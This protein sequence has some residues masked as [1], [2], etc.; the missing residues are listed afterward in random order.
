MDEEGGVT[1]MILRLPLQ[2]QQKRQCG[3]GGKETPRSMGQNRE[4]RRP[5]KHSQLVFNKG[6][7]AVQGR[8]DRQP[9][10]NWW[11]SNRTFIDKMMNLDL[12]LTTYKKLIPMITDLNIKCKRNTFKKI[13]NL[14]DLVLGKEYL[15]LTTKKTHESYI[16]ILDP[17]RLKYFALCKSQLRE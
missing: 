10:N 16:D 6:A 1:L 11:W 9:F 17:I 8:K 14:Q 3:A 7:E 5:T 4:P 13:E 15:G 2:P 12:N